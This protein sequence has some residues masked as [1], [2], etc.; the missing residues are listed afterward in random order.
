MLQRL[1]NRQRGFTLIELLIVVAIIGIIAAIA[2]PNLLNAIDRGKQKRTMADLR[3]IGTAIE[4]Y[5]IDNNFYPV[6]ADIGATYVNTDVTDGDAVQAAV[7]AAASAGPLRLVANCAGIG[8]AQRTIDREGNPH[9]LGVFE[10]VV[11]VNLYLSPPW[12]IFVRV[13]RWRAGFVAA[14]PKSSSWRA[15]RWASVMPGAFMASRR[16]RCSTLW[17]V[18]SLVTTTF[19][20]PLSLSSRTN[21]SASLNRPSRPADP[22]G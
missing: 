19:S 21:S 16:R 9:D 13:S 14:F 5:S 6:A 18:S 10:K 22:R 11:K 8:W 7:D 2:I 15:A 12:D 4:S 1:R 17:M 20:S 3:S